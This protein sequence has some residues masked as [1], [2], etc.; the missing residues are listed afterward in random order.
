MPAL[1][2]QP[3]PSSPDPVVERLDEVLAELA[4]VVADCTPAA[5][6]DRIDRLARLEKL[7]SVTA[8]LQVAEAVRFAKSQVAVQLAANVHPDK[9][10]RG[11]AEQIGL[12]CR[13]C[14]ATAARRLSTAR[15]LWHELPGGE[16]DPAS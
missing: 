8:A 3:G 4:A 13:I 14:P 16:R 9:M 12:A 15:A 5:D 6:A 2:V 1:P 10:G 7:R 11:I